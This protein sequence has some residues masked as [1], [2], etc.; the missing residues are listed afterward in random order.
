[1]P[2]KS[3]PAIKE[4]T[5]YL[6]TK[7][8]EARPGLKSQLKLSPHPPASILT[9]EEIGER[10]L[11]AAILLLF[12]PKGNDLFLVLIRRSATVRHHQNQISFPGGQIEKGESYE[13]AAIRE[14]REE[15]G[16]EIDNQEVVGQLTPLYV[17]ASNYCI[18]PVVAVTPKTPNFKPG[19]EEVAE[20]IE[21]PLKHLLDPRNL[22]F[23]IRS[24][25]G[26]SALVPYF[27]YNQHQIWG[28]T[29]MILSELLDIL[30]KK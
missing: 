17:Q 19:A 7:L 25:R 10:C 9:I 22:A 27:A 29:A 1:M 20:I 16:V 3:D 21:V 14:A 30:R 13:A 8:K 23:E 26:Q 5:E 4:L 18:F 12:Y 28:A 2:E 6:K 11:K 15:L 24:I